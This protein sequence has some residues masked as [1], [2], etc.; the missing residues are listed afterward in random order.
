MK[1]FCLPSDFKNETLDSYCELNCIYKT[2]KVFETYGQ[3]APE[4]K[5]GSCRASSQLPAID[6]IGLEKYIKY[7]LDK[8]I[9]FNYVINPTCMDNEDLT[10]KGYKKIRSFFEMLSDMGV[11]SVTIALPSLM[12][13]CKAAVPGMK[14]KA[15]AVCQINSPHKAKFYEELG[16][17]R[18]VMDEDIYRKFDLIK[19]ITSA[20]SMGKEVIINSFCICD[21]PYKMF[22]Y[23]SLS[24]NRK[25]QEIYPY[26]SRRCKRSH[27]GA[28][29]YMHINWIRP[30]DLHYYNELGIEYF[31]I[32]GRT[33]VF[34]GNPA[35]AVK[36][37]M[38][39]SY[40]G[41]LISLMELFSQNRSLCIADCKIDNK[42]LDGFIERFVE[43]P[44]FCKKLCDEC[45]HC[46][47]YAESSINETDR[48]MLDLMKDMEILV[49]K[50]FPSSY[51]EN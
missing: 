29:K 3:L 7:S 26:Y 33:T 9:E 23:N 2:S 16:I 36:H 34:S 40:D 5:F 19:D 15:S 37:Y 39:E 24:H 10:N 18:F 1:Y 6:R 43:N 51:E 38:D 28:E 22:H 32:Q 31:K 27:L 46:K 17:D 25:G 42:K 8:G 35:K 30:E 21:C 4:T 41:D 44:G 48:I 12:E 49:F 50:G 13:I 11:N 14:I 20:T 47:K 45:G